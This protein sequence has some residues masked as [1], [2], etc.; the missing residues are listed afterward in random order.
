MSTDHLFHVIKDKSNNKH[1]FTMGHFEPEY[2]KM[3]ILKLQNNFIEY[4]PVR[5]A[6]VMN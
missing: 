4:I 6:T 3:T 5:E 2:F 1:F